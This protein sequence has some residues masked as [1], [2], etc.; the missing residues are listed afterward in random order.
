M[1]RIGPKMNLSLCCGAISNPYQFQPDRSKP[2][3]D[4][5]RTQPSVH[6]S[7]TEL[8]MGCQ[9]DKKCLSLKNN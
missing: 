5:T 8:Q 7:L 4:Y 3:S 2:H 6:G 9:R 1:H